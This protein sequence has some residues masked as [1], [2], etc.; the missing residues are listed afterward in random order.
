M[1]YKKRKKAASRVMVMTVLVITVLAVLFVLASSQVFKVRNV[2]VVGNRNLLKEEV[3]AQSGIQIGDNLL[4]L[5]DAELKKKL[6]K[7]RYIEY[8]GHEFDYRGTLTLRINERLGM[9]VVNAYGRYYVLDASGVVL[10][11]TGSQFPDTVAGPTISGL[12]MDNNKR[13]VVVIGEKLPVRDSGQL[14]SMERVLTELDNI[15]MLGR[16]SQ[17]DV[18]NLDN[19]YL[20]TT[21]GVRIVLGDASSLRTKLLIAR[22]VLSV[23]EPLGMVR[24]SK[25]DVSSGREAH[26]IPDTL[27]TVTPVPTA[28]PTPAP[29]ETPEN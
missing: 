24:G 28:T 16:I 6:E 5:S 29:A 14:E 1:R 23:R 25:I 15:G 4:S 12:L 26:Y 9:G 22:E 27:P 19:L 21:D 13:V 20:M 18:K 11:C 8:I 7:N 3:V 17:L 10:E 2:L